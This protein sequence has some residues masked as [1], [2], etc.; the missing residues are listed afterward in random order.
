MRDLLQRSM[1][2]WNV[3]KH[4][5]H[6]FRDALVCGNGYLAINVL[7]SPPVRNLNPSTTR[8][9]SENEFEVET[10][11]GSIELIHTGVVHVRGV[12]QLVSQYGMSPLE[13]VLP[14]VLTVRALSEAA[15]AAQ[16]MLSS[17]QVVPSPAKEWAQATIEQRDRVALVTTT[18]I[19]E[20]F[21]PFVASLPVP[22][23][24][25]Y[26]AGYEAM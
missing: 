7:G 20:L 26:F 5:N 21:A 16:T 15:A 24:E 10:D 6:T 18:S 2:L 19:N 1:T 8:I 3:H 4:I 12:E 23:A 14:Q 22:P 17:T 11:D 25:L 13:A 9:V